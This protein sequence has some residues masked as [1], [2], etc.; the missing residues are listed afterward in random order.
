MGS[1]S[2]EFKKS[3]HGPGIFSTVQFSDQTK[4][5]S[6]KDNLVNKDRKVSTNTHGSLHSS[7]QSQNKMSGS[8]DDEEETLVVIRKPRVFNIKS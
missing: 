7:K 6:S 4:L 5:I 1:K 2:Y 8:I 3:G